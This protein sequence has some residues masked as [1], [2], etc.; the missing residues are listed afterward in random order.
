MTF[1]GGRR[2]DQLELGRTSR[3]LRYPSDDVHPNLVEFPVSFL[4]SVAFVTSM[5]TIPNL[6]EFPMSCTTL[7]GVLLGPV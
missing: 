7:L 2:D 4:S 6:I 3:G 1:L 5:A